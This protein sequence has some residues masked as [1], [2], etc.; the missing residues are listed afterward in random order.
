MD[1]SENN[2]QIRSGYTINR[3]LLPHGVNCKRRVLALMSRPAQT[4]DDKQT[5]TIKWHQATAARIER[6]WTMDTIVDGMRR[7]RRVLQQLVH[8]F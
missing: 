7:Q 5:S 1:G 2:K 8:S 6:K 3:D 4:S